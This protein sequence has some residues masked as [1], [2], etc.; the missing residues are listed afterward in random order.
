MFG[1]SALSEHTF[2]DDGIY[3]PTVGVV[4]DFLYIQDVFLTFPLRANQLANFDLNVNKELL[5]FSLDVNQLANL[6]L[7]VNKLQNHNLTINQ[8]LNFT[9]EFLFKFLWKT[10]FP[11]EA[12]NV[13]SKA[14]NNPICV[15]LVKLK[16]KISSLK[17]IM[18]PI[19]PIV[20]PSKVF[21][22]GFFLK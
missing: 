19:I 15:P 22:E 10:I 13:P 11:V 12:Q 4:P 6:D 16:L 20:A 3:T 1:M 17:M 8:L 9:V 7:K 5:E 21:K 14:K 18:I 2:A